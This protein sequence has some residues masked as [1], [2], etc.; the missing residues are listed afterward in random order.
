MWL[1][2]ST[3]VTKASRFLAGIRTVR[4]A[5][6]LRLGTNREILCLDRLSLPPNSYLDVGCSVGP[7]FPVVIKTLVLDSNSPRIFKAVDYSLEH[8][9]QIYEK[10]P[11]Y[12]R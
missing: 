4:V 12:R 2:P 11:Q 8:K 10:F 5:L 3:W 9:K 1:A 7:A 6:R